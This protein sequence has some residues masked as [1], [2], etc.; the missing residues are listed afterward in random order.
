MSDAM[1]TSRHET[2]L[3]WYFSG[4]PAGDC[5]LRSSCGAQ[6]EA[7]AAT[8]QSDLT[9]APEWDGRTRFDDA[10]AMMPMP[11]Q[12]R[13]CRPSR[14]GASPDS[15]EAAT[16][17]LAAVRRER[18]VRA[19]LSGIHPIEARALA[20]FYAARPEGSHTGLGAL[21]EIRGVVAYLA[22]EGVRELARIAGRRKAD[23]DVQE[24]AEAKARLRRYV[25]Q[26]RA[27]VATARASYAAA[28]GVAVRVERERRAAR[29]AGGVQ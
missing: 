28:A 11:G 15:T 1:W 25:D 16:A 3:A 9:R 26:A 20:E 27:L 21:G 4:G 2:D 8:A 22:G 10:G 29:F 23:G 14:S 18:I 12:V 7:I 24:R 6:L 19:A 17:A 5:G 13:V